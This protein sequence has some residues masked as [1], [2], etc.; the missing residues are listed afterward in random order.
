MHA[1][2]ALTDHTGAPGCVG[3]PRTPP[4]GRGLDRDAVSGAVNCQFT[5]EQSPRL[6]NAVSSWAAVGC[7]SHRFALPLLDATHADKYRNIATPLGLALANASGRSL[8]SCGDWLC[9]TA[10]PMAVNVIGGLLICLGLEHRLQVNQ[11]VVE[12]FSCDVQ[13]LKNL[14]ITHRVIHAG[15]GAS[16]V[17]DVLCAQDSQLLG[18]RR[19]FDTQC[20]LE[21]RDCPLA[22]T[23]E[24]KDA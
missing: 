9:S 14:R 15:P 2:P 20:E 19:P 1:C 23:K 7:L 24:F 3:T 6:S 22:L 18:N 17:D 21:L 13:Q 11:V 8:F 12:D 5:Q 4:Q 16:R 10:A